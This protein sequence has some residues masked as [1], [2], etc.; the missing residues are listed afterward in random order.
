[1]LNEKILAYI[2]ARKRI[3]ILKPYYYALFFTSKRIIVAALTDNSLN[4]ASYYNWE[5][6][7]RLSECLSK[8]DPEQILKDHKENFEISYSDVNKI[9]M[10]HWAATSFGKAEFQIHRI[11]IVT[12]NKKLKFNICEKYN[13]ILEKYVPIIRSVLRDK[14]DHIPKIDRLRWYPFSMF[15]KEIRDC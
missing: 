1:M 6:V 11:E 4:A 3:S 14:F 10:K 13:E 2:P 15:F 8:L 12:K 9:R 5:P 7:R